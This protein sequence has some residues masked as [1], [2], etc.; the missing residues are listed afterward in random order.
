MARLASMVNPPM[1]A[2]SFSSTALRAQFADSLA[3]YLSSQNVT[4]SLCIVPLPSG[5]PPCSFTHWAKYFDASRMFSYGVRLVSMAVS[6]ITLIGAP[7]SPVP[8]P[9]PA[10]VA[11][12]PPLAVVAL[13]PPPDVVAAP[14]DVVAAPAAVV[15]AESSSSP[16]AART[17]APTATDATSTRAR[18]LR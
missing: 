17:R 16:H 5:M 9:P 13:P 12:P 10:V 6:V 7:V 2:T 3:S 11:L 15:A 18:C 4:S 1:L 8:P 14:P